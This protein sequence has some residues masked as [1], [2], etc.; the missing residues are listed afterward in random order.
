MARI[1]Q[2]ELERL[3]EEVSVLRLVEAAAAGVAAAAVQHL[4]HPALRLLHV[5]LD[6]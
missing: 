1:P 4:A 2:Q 5:L 3:K 6:A